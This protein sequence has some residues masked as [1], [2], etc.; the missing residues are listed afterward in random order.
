MLKVYEIQCF[1]P[2][3]LYDVKKLNEF[4]KSSCDIQS[5]TT[6]H[7]STVSKR[8]H[9]EQRTTLLLI[10]QTN[11][12]TLDQFDKRKRLSKTILHCLLT[13]LE[14]TVLVHLRSPSNSQRKCASLTYV[15]VFGNMCDGCQD[16]RWKILNGLKVFEEQQVLVRPCRKKNGKKIQSNNS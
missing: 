10:R 6:T 1:H 11:H 15:A 7:N 14:Q 12:C 2:K 16:V 4:V 8:L 5:T 13:R 3:E 9:H